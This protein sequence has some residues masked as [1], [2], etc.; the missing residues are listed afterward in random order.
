MSMEDA[1]Y[2]FQILGYTL[3]AAVALGAVLY[4]WAE[5]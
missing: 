1:I 3:L 4:W 2:C 5:R